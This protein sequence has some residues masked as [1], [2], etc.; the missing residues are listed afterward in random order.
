LYA[1]NKNKDLL[2][3]GSFG[4]VY[5][6]KN[7]ITLKPAAIKVIEKKKLKGNEVFI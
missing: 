7:L 3:A 4:A 2:G 5:R 6:T 1:I